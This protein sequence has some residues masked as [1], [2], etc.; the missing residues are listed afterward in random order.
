MDGTVIPS[1]RTEARVNLGTQRSK[2]QINKEDTTTEV[3]YWMIAVICG[4]L[5]ANPPVDD[6]LDVLKKGI[7]LVDRKPFSMKRWNEGLSLDVST[8]KLLPIWVQFPELD[9]RY[10]AL[11]SLSKLD[12][13]LGIPIKTDKVTKEKSAL[14]YARL[15]VEMKMGSPFPEHIDFINNGDMVVRQQVGYEWKPL[16]CNHYYM[17]GHEEADCRK[18]KKIGRN[19]ESET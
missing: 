4:V 16:K 8:L 13:A 7:F 19:R 3:E 14:H 18:K 17:M 12:S 1:A 5:R 2:Q 9:I 11:E 6:K 10:L 15:L